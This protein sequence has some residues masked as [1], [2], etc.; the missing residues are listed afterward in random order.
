[1][2]FRTFQRGVGIHAVA[3]ARITRRYD[4]RSGVRQSPCGETRSDRPLPRAGGRVRTGGVVDRPPRPVTQPFAG[5]AFRRARGEQIEEVRG[6]DIALVPVGVA[7]HGDESTTVDMR[8]E[9]GDEIDEPVEFELQHHR[10][11]HGRLLVRLVDAVGEVALA[12][13]ERALLVDDEAQVEEV[14]AVCAPAA[15][16]VPA[17]V[18]GARGGA[19]ESG[20]RGTLRAQIGGHAPRHAGH[21]AFEERADDV[22]VDRFQPFARIPIVGQT[23]RAVVG[24]RTLP[25]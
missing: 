6:V 14:D 1:M 18:A 9:R 19:G 12:D 5:H 17:G 7:Q 4:V 13:R 2:R 25:R 16:G 20:V 24:G 21:V 23:P 11:N 15:G 3:A 8:V 22:R 10:R